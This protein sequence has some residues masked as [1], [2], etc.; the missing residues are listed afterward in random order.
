MCMKWKIP[1]DEITIFS[2][3]FSLCMYICGTL[4]SISEIHDADCWFFFIE[5]YWNANENLLWVFFATLSVEIRFYSHIH[6]PKKVILN[7]EEKTD[8]PQW[9]QEQREKICLMLRIFVWSGKRKSIKKYMNGLM[10][11]YAWCACTDATT[12]FNL[13]PNKAGVTFICMF[14]VNYADY[15]YC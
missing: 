2:F 15:V 11:M 7:V 5:F 1:P 3:F 4:T 9:N 13:M 10:K 8:S 12:Y 6:I 14:A